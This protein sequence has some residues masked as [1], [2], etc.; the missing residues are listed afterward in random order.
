MNKR[1][2][3]I[4]LAVL[5]VLAAAAP[6]FAYQQN[7]AVPNYPAAGSEEFYDPFS[8]PSSEA[9]PPEFAEGGT[10]YYEDGAS[11]SDEFSA[12]SFDSA[13]SKNSIPAAES[14]SVLRLIASLIIA[15]FIAYLI[16]N[17]VAAPLKSVSSSV[18][19][20]N[21]V[22]SQRVELTSKEDKFLYNKTVTAV[23]AKPAEDTPDINRQGSI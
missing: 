20:N 22:L 1:L 11:A 12:F 5:L 6:V 9:L 17:A 3:S 7:Y 23:L 8:V 16:M 10:Y 15:F 4:L 2:F 18:N 13:N 19:A 21:Y 14:F